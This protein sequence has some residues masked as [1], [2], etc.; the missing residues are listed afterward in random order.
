MTQ[1]T[2]LGGTHGRILHVD[3]TTGTTMVETPDIEVYRK[4]VGGRG[5]V[6]YLLL[7]DLPPESDP[8][9][10]ENMLIF[11]P[12]I[13]QG[14]GLPGSGRHGVGAKSPLT[15]ALASSE[16]GGWFGHEF[17][18]AGLD[19]LIIR[20]RAKQPVYLWIRDGRAEIRPATHL[21]GKNTAET[22]AL[23][24][25]ELD[26]KRARVAQI[27]I[28][29]ESLCLFSAIM[30]DVCRAA[31]RGGLGAVMGSKNL[32]AV[33]VSGNTTPQ[34]ADRTRLRAVAKWLIENYET[35]VGW[36]VKMGTTIALRGLAMAGGLPTQNFREPVFEG[37]EEI[38][39]D[40][41]METLS[42]DRDTCVACPIHCKQVVSYDDP[43]GRYTVDPAFGGP[44]YEAVAAFGSNCGISDLPAISKANELCNAYGLDVIS[45]GVV[46][47]FVMEC[48]ESGLLTATDTQGYIPRW[49]DPMAIIEGVELISKRQ[50]FG[51]AMA[52]GVRRLAARVGHGAE[53]IAV[54]VKGLEVPMHEPRFKVAQGV[55]YAVAPVGAD[56][57]MNIHD[58]HYASPGEGVDR[59]NAVLQ[60]DPLPPGE[61]S[62]RKMQLFFHEVR[63]KHFHDCAVVCLFY[64]YRYHHLAEALSAVTGSEY[65]IEDV[66][67][68]GERAQAL[69]R[70]FNMREGFARDDDQLPPRL[71]EPFRSGPLSGA[72]L[73]PESFD[74]A[75]RRYYE[76]M[77]W[78]PETG[79][80]TTSCLERLGVNG[81]FGEIEKQIA[82]APNNPDTGGGK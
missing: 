37:W 36:G 15:G 21:W 3:L 59:V 18:R 9:G 25:E 22:E 30:H 79:E 44:E 50:G 12:G 20:G 52:D 61:M 57:M 47:A 14:T 75:L 45:T 48:V 77:G 81:L 70:L 68:V 10:P 32:K 19:A 60:T 63:W 43:L 24:R 56:H 67:I 13:L 17:K 64:P 80:P 6:A 71:M 28:A 31:G 35:K 5:L 34:I 40:R 74:W 49:G 58:V 8:L 82:G 33:A 42:R 76:M 1:Q 46:L 66:L 23:I 51:D 7:R 39:G 26:D 53:R 27:G 16:A 62:E 11:A 65:S 73:T 78:D 72:G 41:L 54:H 38:T 55:G 2:R 29:G 4:L 69:S